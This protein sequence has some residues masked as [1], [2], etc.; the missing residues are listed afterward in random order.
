MSEVK[1]GKYGF[2]EY[3]VHIGHQYSYDS[4]SGIGI[5]LNPDAGVQC[6]QL[7]WSMTYTQYV[8]IMPQLVNTIVAHAYS[9]SRTDSESLWDNDNGTSYSYISNFQML[10]SGTGLPSSSN[11][12][13]TMNITVL[14]NYV[15]D[16]YS[17]RTSF[18]WDGLFYDNYSNLKLVRGGMHC[19]VATQI[20]RIRLYTGGRFKGMTFRTFP[21]GE[22][23]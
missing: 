19:K 14:N 18:F 10:G 23:T 2:G 5:K 7:S 3:E 9:A 11:K 13:H 4:Y 21:I 20:N 1:I 22:H 8:F 12:V 17:G 6:F 15:G 16:E